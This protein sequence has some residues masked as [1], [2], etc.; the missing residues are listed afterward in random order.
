MP[1]GDPRDG[2]FY[3]TLTLT[4]DSYISSYSIL[5]LYVFVLCCYSVVQA[6][7]EQINFYDVLNRGSYMSAHVL[8]NLSNVFRKSDKMRGRVG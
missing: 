5:V 3:P 2:F 6:F 4:M 8:L 1:M 7:D